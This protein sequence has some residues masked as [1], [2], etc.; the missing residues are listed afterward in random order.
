MIKINDEE[1]RLWAALI[2]EY[3]GIVIRPEKAYLIENRLAEMTSEMGCPTFGELYQRIRYSADQAVK[4]KVINLMTTQETS[5]FRD[6]AVFKALES[7][8]RN[9]VIPAMRKAG[10][11][12][13]RL[14]VWSAAC[15]H[16][17]EPYTLAMILAEVVPDIDNWDLTIVATD[18][19]DN[20]F[21]KASLGRYTDMEVKRGLD[22]VR[23][24]RYFVNNNGLWQICDRIRAMIYFQK[25]NLI[26]DNLN[27][28]GTFDL[29]FCRNVL[30]YFNQT[31]KQAV[32]EKISRA[33]NREAR[34]FV[35]STES[36]SQISPMF[37]PVHRYDVVYYTRS[38]GRPVPC[39]AGQTFGIAPLAFSGTRA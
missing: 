12:Y 39:S 9:E 6:P 2:Y 19:A 28:L 7:L 35:G 8:L 5:F 33:L 15:S 29:V 14:R 20:A 26:T 18:I 23:L 22:Q 13:P 11:N 24:K 27:S 32:L 38:N 16:G 34:L 31:T 36:A 4:E 3:T 37:I 30:I 1:F 10:S 25:V 17:Q 21:R